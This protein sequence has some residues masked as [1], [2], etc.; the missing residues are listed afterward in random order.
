M[1]INAVTGLHRIVLTRLAWRHHE[2]DRRSTMFT[3][4]ISPLLL[5]TGLIFASATASAAE[6]RSLDG[7]RLFE[8]HACINCHGAAGKS[9]VREM[10]PRLDG[11][12]GREVLARATGTED[13]DSEAARWKRAAFSSQSCDAPPSQ[14]DLQLI[15]DWL[16]SQR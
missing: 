1:T 12:S 7:E 5:A 3:H 10:V 2:R 15:A 16:A 8:H 9:P 11:L 13:Q 14:A 6:S 4:R